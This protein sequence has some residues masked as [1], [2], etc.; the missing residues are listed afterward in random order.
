MSEGPPLSHAVGP[1]SLF[2][3]ALLA[4]PRPPVAKAPLFHRIVDFTRGSALACSASRPPQDW[5]CN[6]MALTSSLP[7]YLLPA[8]AFSFTAQSMDWVIICHVVMPEPLVSPPLAI[9]NTPLAASGPRNC[10][11]M[12]PLLAHP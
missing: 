6:E 1:W 7:K 9:T 5:P 4:P 11:K 10:G 8:R 2:R 12:V 3:S